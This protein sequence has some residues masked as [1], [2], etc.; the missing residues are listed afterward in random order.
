MDAFGAS[1]LPMGL[2]IE[3][4]LTSFHTPSAA[5]PNFVYSSRD[6]RHGRAG[7]S[8]DSRRSLHGCVRDVDIVPWSTPSEEGQIAPG[9]QNEEGLEDFRNGAG[10]GRPA[11][12]EPSDLLQHE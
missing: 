2:A 9:Q 4:F 5:F 1:S 12:R 8:I 11:Q 6:E 10:S 3:D 7:V